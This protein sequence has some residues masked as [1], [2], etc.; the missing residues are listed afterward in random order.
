MVVHDAPAFRDLAKDEGKQSAQIFAVGHFQV[1]AAA[2]PGGIASKHVNL[3]L[4]EIQ[5]THLVAFALVTGA[6]ALQRRVPAASDVTAGIKGEF[7]RLP[8]APHEGVDIT[9]IPGS[10]LLV[11]YGADGA[12]SGRTGGRCWIRLA[13]R[14]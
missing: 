12:R 4:A 10:S 8:V 5:L 11:Q 13:G 3:Q 6:I 1:P 2:H 7:G 9:T 14:P